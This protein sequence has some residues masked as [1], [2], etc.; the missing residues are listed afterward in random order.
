MSSS[1][2][3]SRVRYLVADSLGVDVKELTPDVSLPDDLAA[4]SLDLVE[5]SLALEEALGI[6]LPERRMAEV[7]S[8]GDLLAAVVGLVRERGE[9]PA[10]EPEPVFVWART[11]AV[12]GGRLG[13]E[14]VDWFTPYL[15]ETIGDDA[16]Q[17]G[18]GARVTVAVAGG[19]DERVLARV[20]AELAWLEDRGVR[21]H[22]HPRSQPDGAAV[23]KTDAA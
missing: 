13:V 10:I 5:L 18:P 14:R 6:N 23:L 21:L 19:E 15:A 2:I 22:V 20:H 12:D 8:Y 17:A 7:R 16:L 11:V 9:T 3:E 4:D 1:P